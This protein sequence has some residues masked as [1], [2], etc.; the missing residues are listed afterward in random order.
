MPASD[1]PERPCVGSGFCCKQAPCPYGKALP[2]SR[3]CVYLAVWDQSETVA[4]RY[5]C[6]RYDFI[7]AQPGSDFSPAFGAGCSSALFNTD[8]DA[9]LIELRRR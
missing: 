2:G 4:T 7:K 6:E 5:R 9:I 8:R 1:A 3:Q